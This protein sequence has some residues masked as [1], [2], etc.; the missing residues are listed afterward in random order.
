MPKLWPDELILMTRCTES[1]IKKLLSN[2]LEETYSIDP[3]PT[4]ASKRE[5]LHAKKLSS[6]EVKREKA[7]NTIS[8]PAKSTIPVLPKKHL[9]KAKILSEAKANEKLFPGKELVQKKQ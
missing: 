2:P 8:P 3:K 1:Q 7:Y 4:P 9:E 5:S 6:T